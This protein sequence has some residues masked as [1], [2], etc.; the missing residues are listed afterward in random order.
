MKI[1]EQELIELI[2]KEKIIQLTYGPGY[3]KLR[4]IKQNQWA[5]EFVKKMRSPN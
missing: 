2:K 4:D 5:F 3:V 1:T